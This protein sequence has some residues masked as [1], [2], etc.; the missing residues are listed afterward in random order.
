[1]NLKMKL[2]TDFVNQMQ[3]DSLFDEFIFIREYNKKYV[4][5]KFKKIIVIFIESF[6][7][8]I[9]IINCEFWEG[10]GGIL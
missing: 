8:S 3:N 9:S 7:Y 4:I 2:F 6:F 10:V 1:M 5:V